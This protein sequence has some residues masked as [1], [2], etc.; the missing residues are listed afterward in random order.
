M[1]R[2]MAPV[3]SNGQPASPLRAILVIEKTGVGQIDEQQVE[4]GF[5]EFERADIVFQVV[6]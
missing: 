3:D 2:V 4:L 1:M 6:R 5:R